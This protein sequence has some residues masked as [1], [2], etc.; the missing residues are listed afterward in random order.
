MALEDEPKE[1]ENPIKKRPSGCDEPKEETQITKRPAGHGRSLKAILSSLPDDDN[2][3]TDN[4]EDKPKKQKNSST[5]TAEAVK[6]KE[7]QDEQQNTEL[8]SCLKS[9]V[10]MNFNLSLE[11]DETISDLKDLTELN[12]ASQRI[13]NVHA[14]LLEGAS[15][16]MTSHTEKMKDLMKNSKATRFMDAKAIALSQAKDAID[17]T[18]ELTTEEYR[19]RSGAIGGHG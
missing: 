14:E 18:K 2:S 9:G 11:V 7:V 5:L 6:D 12:T 3:D 8:N 16:S 19:S 4:D 13:A 1:G 17:D 10:S 15:A